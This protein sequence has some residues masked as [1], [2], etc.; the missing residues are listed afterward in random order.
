[1]CHI[2]NC[3]DTYSANGRESHTLDTRVAQLQVFHGTRPVRNANTIARLGPD[4]S[5]IGAAHGARFGRGFYTSDH[6]GIARGYTYEAG[7][8]CVCTA[9]LGICKLQGLGGES[10]TP[11]SLLEQGFHSVHDAG[12]KEIVLFH[13]DSMFTKYIIDLVP[14]DSLEEQIAVERLRVQKAHQMAEDQRC[15]QLLVWTSCRIICTT[16]YLFKLFLTCKCIYVNVCFV[17]CP[18]LSAGNFTWTNKPLVA[19]WL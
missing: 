6:I 14:D 11:G 12:T 2:Y 10:E 4:F 1:M 9:L 5:R 8:I 13:P 15:R 3:L 16:C 19:I 18:F 17:F 7:S